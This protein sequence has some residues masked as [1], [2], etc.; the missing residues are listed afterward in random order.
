[1]DFDQILVDGFSI[2]RSQGDDDPLDVPG[3]LG[4]ESGQLGVGDG[5]ESGSE[6]DQPVINR[7]DAASG[8]FF[9]DNIM[10]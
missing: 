3:G 1:M 10:S 6:L 9:E 4:E 7:K 2:L 8:V 5:L